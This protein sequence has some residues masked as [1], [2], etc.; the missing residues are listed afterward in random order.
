MQDSPLD[1][2]PFGYHN[3]GLW[4]KVAAIFKCMISFNK[5]RYD[6][7]GRR[8]PIDR[9]LI[10]GKAILMVDITLRRSFTQ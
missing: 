3:A 4:S 1:A 5:M 6:E 2:M 7:Y 8:V 9:D 10:A